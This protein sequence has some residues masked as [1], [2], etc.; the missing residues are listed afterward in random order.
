VKKKTNLHK[1]QVRWLWKVDLHIGKTPQGK[2]NPKKG[3]PQ[4]TPPPANNETKVPQEKKK[5]NKSTTPQR[6]K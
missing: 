5:K 4:R 1:K 2:I 6:K 3:T